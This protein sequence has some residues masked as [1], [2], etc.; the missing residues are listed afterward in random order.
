MHESQETAGPLARNAP[1]SVVY[2]IR[3]IFDKLSRCK[4]PRSTSSR[5]KC[6]N[7][8]VLGNIRHRN[9]DERGPKGEYRADGCSTDMARRIVK[10]D[11]R[12]DQPNW[13]EEREKDLHNPAE[14][15]RGKDEY[16]GVV[17]ICLG[18]TI[19]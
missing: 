16:V 13:D 2:L 15:L 4:Q 8:V 9:H 3:S 7:Q 14:E 19:R 10:Q 5:Y 11:G 1:R 17:S 12:K 6:Q 18:N